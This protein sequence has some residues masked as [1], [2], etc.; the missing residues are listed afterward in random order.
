[1]LLSKT[2]TG[3]VISR[4]VGHSTIRLSNGAKVTTN[5]SSIK[6]GTKVNVAMNMQTGKVANVYLHG[7]YLQEPE[8]NQPPEEEYFGFYEEN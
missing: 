2:I 7:T 6:L 4:K 3:I 5:D 1:M 8:E